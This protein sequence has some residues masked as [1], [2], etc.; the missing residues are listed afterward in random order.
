MVPWIVARD[1]P[2]VSEVC[3]R[4][5]VSESEL[6][7]DLNLLFMCGVYPYT[8]DALIDV[9][10]DGG[11]VWVRFADWFRRPLR[12]TAAE[13]LALVAAARAS[14]AVPANGGEA[15]A[16]AASKLETALGGGGGEALDIELGEASQEVLRTLQTA[17]QRRRKVLVDYYSFGRDESG[18]RVLQPWRV[19]SSEGH[20]YV[21][22][23]CERVSGKRLFRVD[24]AR[25]ATALDEAFDP[26]PEAAGQGP[27]PTFESRPEDP[28]VVLDLSP[29]ARWVAAQYP[30][31]GTRD[32]PDGHLEVTLRVGSAGWLQRVLLIAGPDARVVAGAEGVLQEAARRVLAVYEAKDRA[33]AS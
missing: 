27:V 25:S 28:L 17:V 6:M 11:R 32:L 4:F 23:W 8:P 30:N 2:T 14:L 24:R 9:D 12:L 5:E 1:G 16:R 13:G 10:V 21:L 29:A 31:E 22:A 19:F 3:R 33:P 15:L 20:W 18:E 7:A 26:P